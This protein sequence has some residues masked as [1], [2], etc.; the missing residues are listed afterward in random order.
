MT[1]VKSHAINLFYT[2]CFG[3]RVSKVK[4]TIKSPKMQCNLFWFCIQTD[5]KLQCFKLQQFVQSVFGSSYKQV[6]FR[7]SRN[8]N[9]E[10]TALPQTLVRKA[11]KAFLKDL[12]I[13]KNLAG[14]PKTT[15]L[16]VILNDINS[17]VKSNQQLPCHLEAAQEKQNN[18]KLG[19][20]CSQTKACG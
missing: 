13:E 3:N 2:D 7:V 8:L 19:R 15:C 4:G 20:L 12:L 16:I 17:W 18:D 9:S 1:T 10:L 6:R 11:L 5:Q 14:R